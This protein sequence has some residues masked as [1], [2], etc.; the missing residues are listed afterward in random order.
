[1]MT[2]TDV[3]KLRKLKVRHSEISC[4]NMIESPALIQQEKNVKII[5]HS[6][7][8][9]SVP[10]TPGKNFHGFRTCK[11]TSQYSSHR[12]RTFSH[13]VTALILVFQNIKTAAM[14]VFQTNPVGVELFSNVNAFFCSNEFV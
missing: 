5:I 4:V 13:D 12:Y 3:A 8:N 14:L 10:S 11:T 6:R 7:R 1:M 2:Y 9:C